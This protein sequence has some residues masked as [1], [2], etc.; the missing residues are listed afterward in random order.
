MRLLIDCGTG[1]LAKLQ[2]FLPLTELTAVVISHIHADHFFDLIPLRYAYRYGLGPPGPGPQLYLPPGGRETLQRM[3]APFGSDVGE[4]FLPAVFRVGEFDPGASL[5]VGPV[6]LT[7]APGRHYVASWA[8]A[9]QGDRRIVFTS[10]TGPSKAVAELAKGASLL[11]SEATY[12]SL[13]EERGPQR[14][15]L[16]GTE[17]GELAAYAGPERVLLTHQWPNRDPTLPLQQ[18]RAVFSGNIG[19]AEPGA[20]YIV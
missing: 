3:V 17:A 16:T 2:H 11:I 10:D 7:F 13:E 18:A 19:M 9:I 4:D 15:H 8:L 20:I 12:L 6:K 14:G 1:V 5:H